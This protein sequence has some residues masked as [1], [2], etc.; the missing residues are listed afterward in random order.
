MKK[1]ILLIT[2]LLL[3]TNIYALEYGLGGEVYISDETYVEYSSEA[4]YNEMIL[5]PFLRVELS[6]SSYVE[7]FIYYKTYTE[8]DLDSTND[9]IL[10]DYSYSYIGG[11]FDYGRVAYQ[12]N[13]VSLN[14]SFETIFTYGLEPEGEDAF[15]YNDYTSN[16]LNLMGNV[17]ADIHITKNL[18]LRFSHQIIRF[19]AYYSD[20]TPNSTEYR[21]LDFFFDTKYTGF[22]PNLSF[23]YMF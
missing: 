19:T 9:D 1:N 17:S 13:L 20:W 16:A 2:F 10:D 6:N 22:K 18:K 8:R 11:G 15:E 5:K 14:Y 23:Y 3:I 7:P 21:L 4:I 12:N